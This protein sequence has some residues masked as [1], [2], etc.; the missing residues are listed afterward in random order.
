MSLNH[1]NKILWQPQ[2]T[3]S[4]MQN[5]HLPKKHGW[6][7]LNIGK[8]ARKYIKAGFAVLSDVL[9]HFILPEVLNPLKS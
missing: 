8:N 2:L 6:N 9:G 7:V 1:Q 4:T 5:L 3:N